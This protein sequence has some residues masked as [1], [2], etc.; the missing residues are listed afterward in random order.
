MT[1]LLTLSKTRVRAGNLGGARQQQGLSL[2]ELL[3]AITLGMVAVAGAISI[4]LANRTSFRTV[5]GAARLQEN[6]RFAVDYLGRDLREAGGIVCGGKLPHNNVAL[7]TY[8]S[9]TTGWSDWSTGL[10]GYG[11]TDPMP[12]SIISNGAITQASGSQAIVIWSA[13]TGSPSQIKSF[14][15]S[16]KTFSVAASSQPAV[17]GSVFTACDDERV[18]TFT[19]ASGSLTSVVAAQALTAPVK[20][21]GFVNQLTASA[22]YLGAGS[23]TSRALSLYRR[24]LG[25]TSGVPAWTTNEVL[26]NVSEMSITYLKGDGS[27]TPV[28]T[29]YVQAV[30]VSDWANVLAVRIVLTLETPDKVGVNAQGSSALKHYFPF[31]VAIR[32]RLP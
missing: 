32:R 31:T 29:E 27:G 14:N 18:A 5:E 4:Y 20:P 15:P 28:G 25:V 2:V 22:W 7:A 21:G 16:T 23:G 9:A 6:A 24:S 19:L 26:E 12:T 1:C 13:S 10:R 3:I 11:A 30:D 8:P 17:R